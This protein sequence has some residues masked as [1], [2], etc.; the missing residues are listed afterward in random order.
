VEKKVK[1]GAEAMKQMLVDK[2]ALSE[3]Q[4]SIIESQKRL[5]FLE[6]EMLKAKLKKDGQEDAI[7][8]KVQQLQQQ[9]LNYMNTLTAG[10]PGKPLCMTNDNINV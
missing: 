10:Q 9:Q 4:V 3:V 8:D 2:N 1:Q 6:I 5:D 7:P